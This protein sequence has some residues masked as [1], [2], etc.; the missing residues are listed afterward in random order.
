[1]KRID[2]K[3]RLITPTIISGSEQKVPEI[4]S[5]SIRGAVRYWFR[6]LGGSA[7]QEKEVFGGIKASTNEEQNNNE[8]GSSS[9]FILRV[10]EQPG[11]QYLKCNQAAWEIVQRGKDKGKD[12][13]KQPGNFDYI[14]WPMAEKN[15]QSKN[16]RYQKDPKADAR[17]VILNGAEFSLGFLFRRKLDDELYGRFQTALKCWLL[18]GALGTRSRRAYGSVFPVKYEEVVNG[19]NTAWQIPSEDTSFITSLYEL[20]PENALRVIML[21]SGERNAKDA[22]ETCG[23]YLKRFRCG[24][25]FG[26]D[27][28]SEWGKHDHDIPYCGDGHIFRPAIGLPLAQNYRTNR[29]AG[30]QAF[31]EDSDRWASPVM[32]K[33]VQLGEKFYPL[34]IVAK[35]YIIP[36]NSSIQKVKDAKELKEL[37]KRKNPIKTLNLKHNLLEAMIEPDE[38]YW[39]GAEVWVE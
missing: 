28:P 10:I 37:K 17:G 2:V 33:V 27:K 21:S 6:L 24:K 31:F 12:N 36:E 18:L 38:K 8:E 5:P 4:R 3:V 39:K 20:L 29:D 30:F 25:A 23:E 15:P 1:M 7:V 16:P 32:L 22:I 13:H 19:T 11:Q 9:S 35:D 26:K 14:L 34:A